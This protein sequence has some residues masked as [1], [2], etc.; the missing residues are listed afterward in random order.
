MLHLLQPSLNMQ[1]KKLFSGA[2]RWR[3]ST[4]KQHWQLLL[5]GPILVTA[6]RHHWLIYKGLGNVTLCA[7]SVWIHPFLP[8]Q[9]YKPQRAIAKCWSSFCRATCKVLPFHFEAFIQSLQKS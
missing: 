8:L 9:V 5:V 7:G 1:G 2:R 6:G 3:S 4:Q